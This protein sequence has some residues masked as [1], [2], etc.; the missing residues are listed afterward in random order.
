[1]SGGPLDIVHSPGAIAPEEVARSL[2]GLSE[3]VMQTMSQLVERCEHAESELVRARAALRTPIASETDLHERIRD[4][5][6]RLEAESRLSRLGAMAGGIAHEI[7]NPLH[8]AR[9]FAELLEKHVPRGGNERRWAAHVV[10]SIDEVVEIATSLLSIASRQAISRDAVDADELVTSAIASARRVLDGREP[11]RWTITKHVDCPR[12]VGD[13]IKLRSALRNLVANA[14]QALPDGGR[15][16]VRMQLDHG[17]LDIA[18]HDSGLG[19]SAHVQRR[20][21]EAFFTTKCEGSGLGLLLVRAIAELHG[22]RFEV[23]PSASPL[24]GAV[25]RLRLPFEPL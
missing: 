15:I 5:E 4:L 20:L 22:G 17:E 18:V 21:D 2:S 7:R 12:F 13:R 1:M 19:M 8:A 25:T 9:G 3:S 23:S 16:E 14:L 11:E 6:R 10:E 24:G